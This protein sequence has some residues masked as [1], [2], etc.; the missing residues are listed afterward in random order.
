[1]LN[2]RTE[3]TVFTLKYAAYNADEYLSDTDKIWVSVDFSF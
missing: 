2:A 3:R 1:V